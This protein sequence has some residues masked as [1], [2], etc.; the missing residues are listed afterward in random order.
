MLILHK[1]GDKTVAA[2]EEDLLRGIGH[3]PRGL[4]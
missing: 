4:D 3:V 1:R 2:A